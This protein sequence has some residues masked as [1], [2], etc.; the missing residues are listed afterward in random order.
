MP[1]GRNA[2]E[3]RNT[4]GKRDS[5]VDVFELCEPHKHWLCGAENE[6]RGEMFA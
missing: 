6:G 5:P 2:G 4:T 1:E 3:K